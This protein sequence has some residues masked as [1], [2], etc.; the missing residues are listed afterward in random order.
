MG[1]VSAFQI[2]GLKLVFRSADHPPAHF[3]ATKPGKWQ[4]RVFFLLCT[5]RELSFNVRWPPN[6]KG[7]SGREERRLLKATLENKKELQLE[8]ESKVHTLGEV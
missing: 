4:I 8:W 5:E 6:A 2:S 3:H 1:V 7:P